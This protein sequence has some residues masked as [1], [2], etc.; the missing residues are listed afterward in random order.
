MLT[1]DKVLPHVIDLSG[2]WA[3]RYS[4]AVESEGAL[5]LGATE[6]E[7][8]C[9]AMPIPGFWDDRIESIKSAASPASIR[10]NPEYVGIELPMPKEAP[11]ASLPHLVGMGSYECRF[12]APSVGRVT[13]ECGPVFLE[14]HLWVNGK[15]VYT[16]RH[17]STD[18]SVPLDE[19][20][21]PGQENHL[22]LQVRN[23]QPR[24]KGCIT[25]GYKGYSAGVAGDVRL[26]MTGSARIADCY[27]FAVEDGRSI[28]WQ[29]D[30]D[31]VGGQDDL[32]LVWRVV[33]PHDGAI[34]VEGERA[35]INGTNTWEITAQGIEPWSDRHPKLYDVQLELCCNGARS[36]VRSQPFGLRV[37]VADGFQLTLNE[38][39]IYLRGATEHAYFPETCTV[40]LQL[41]VHR[42]HI[43]K[44]KQ[45]GFNWLRFH[46]WV[47]PEA[48]LKAAD[49]LGMLIQVEPPKGADDQE[50]IDI[51]RT[52]RKHPCVVIYC[53]GNE[54][55]LDESKLDQLE[56]WASLLREFAPDSLFNPQEALRG[57]EYGWN[58][59]DLGEDA[60]SE[61]YL[62]NTR[63]L[64]RIKAF[65]DCFG[66]FSWGQ[67]SYS[68]SA[69][70]AATINQR[71]EPYERP[72]LS[73]E[74][75]IHG[76]YLDL[77]LEHRYRDTRIGDELYSK[78]RHH[79]QERGLEHRAAEYY[80]NS[81]A[82]A[83]RHRKYA[84]EAARRCRRLAGY[85]LLGA[86]D[87]HWHRTGYPCGIMNEF[88]ELKVG[89]TAEDVRRYNA[90][91][92][93]LLDH[94]QRWTCRS[95]ESW[96][97]AVLA[98]IFEDKPIGPVRIEWHLR[99]SCGDVRDN[100]QWN[101]NNLV[102][103]DVNELGHVEFTAP[104]VAEAEALSLDVRLTGSNLVIN[105][106][107][108]LWVYPAVSSSMPYVH[109]D[110]S[111][112]TRWPELSK[113][114]ANA[115][116][117]ED[118]ASDQAPTQVRVVSTLKDS[119]VKSLEKGERILLLGSHPFPS[120]VTTFQISCAGRTVGNLAT[121]IHDHPITR[122]L[123]H[124][125]FC[126]WNFQSMLDQGE[127]V[128]F[129]TLGLPFKPII[130]VV[131]SFKDASKQ[132]ALFELRVGEGLLLVCSLGMNP[133]DPASDHLLQMC[134]AYLRDRNST[135]SVSMSPDQLRTIIAQQ[136]QRS[137]VEATDQGFDK[138]AA[139]TSW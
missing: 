70:D 115:Q 13:F 64:E 4:G 1:M 100:G 107:W 127:A 139:L 116:E 8:E 131:S 41:S 96:R 51:M 37:I 136:P 91:S 34:V 72:C 129:D 75:G 23:D 29:V 66:Q 97:G 113:D 137:E 99:D 92:V 62:R 118:A 86:I 11:D 95:G 126:D 80:A 20:V 93:L 18:W 125:G 102:N 110:D 36:D 101:L 33:D 16:Q 119:D 53:A 5:A 57:I 17:Y 48:Y 120:S 114:T 65:S 138:R 10:L 76:T 82:W 122:Q 43:L 7:A 32:Q 98:S 25:R 58:D 73:H 69:G 85:D 78:V 56:R 60:V 134:L 94:D 89:E 103:G 104:D 71:L 133:D 2:D 46:T 112:R 40:P 90:S 84:L 106:Q 24:V 68:S 30:V 19:H 111:L 44:L 3:F 128:A 132:A 124:A 6:S 54:E 15:H 49:E 81:C 61:P 27:M 123:P 22:V 88:Y 21:K 74:L 55:L 109:V 9:F 83:Q 52:C 59:T 121:C 117:L 14:G 63:R 79:L 31:Q 135:T 38:V 77:S 47:P 67:L 28:R 39:P 26:R 12:N 50:W 45:L 87:F 35:V 42:N 105:N 108:S 130:E